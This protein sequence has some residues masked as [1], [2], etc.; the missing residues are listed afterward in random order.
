MRLEIT[1]NKAGRADELP[2]RADLVE[3]LRDAEPAS[4]RPT[5]RVF[6]STPTIKMF[7]RDCTKAGIADADDD[8]R[9]V[10]RH[11]LRTTFVSSLGAC[12]VDS[13]AQIMPARHSPQG[14]T[15]G[16]DQDSGLLDLWAEIAKLPS[17]AP[18]G[19]AERARATGTCGIR[20]RSV[21]RPVVRN[22]G[23]RGVEVAADG[24]MGANR[25]ALDESRKTLEKRGFRV[26]KVV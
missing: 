21:V 1:G 23:Q 15:L 13:R 20:P 12:G 2:L 5:D 6:S 17:V 4:A 16:H 10:D 9:T 22:V 19:A 7:H 14:V 8:G 24:R 18:E 3:A 25:M 11:A 26:V